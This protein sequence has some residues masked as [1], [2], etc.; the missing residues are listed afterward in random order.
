MATAS[1][2][3]VF[4]I[5]TLLASAAAILVIQR[6]P[7]RKYSGGLSVSNTLPGELA[8]I[9]SRDRLRVLFGFLISILASISWA[10]GN[11]LSRYT[12]SAYSGD[13]S[14]IVDISLA[15][16]VSGTIFIVVVSALLH[17]FGGDRHVAFSWAAFAPRQLPYLAALFKAANTYFFVAAVMFVNAAIATTLENLHVL[18]TAII[19]SLIG[20]AL[21]DKSWLLSAFILTTGCVLILRFWDQSIRS[22]Q[23]M[24][25]LAFAILAGISLA[26]FIVSWNERINANDTAVQNAMRTAQFLG[27][28]T[29]ILYLISLCLYF[30]I[31]KGELIP[32]SHISSRHLALQLLNGLFN[33]GLT[34]FLMAESLRLMKP[35]AQLAS[36]LLALGI[37]YA[38]LFTLLIEA[39]VLGNSVS[40]IQWVGAFLFSVGF[41]VIK[42][43]LSRPP[44]NNAPS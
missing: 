38:V 14:A 17:I 43:N 2:T 44:E 19:V 13:I 30:T 10:G 22:P 5:L 37:S 6:R 39:L 16:Y 20:R 34:Y 36:F 9:D 35:A 42:E 27:I 41:A 18:W 15:N 1:E 24:L 32:F 28:T 25:G 7:W 29:V 31:S 40:P 3:V 21:L 12:A 26:L 33:I 11:V 4:A 23:S 8:R